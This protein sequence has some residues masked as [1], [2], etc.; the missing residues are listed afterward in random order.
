M[1]VH[2][3]IVRTSAY[4]TS[5]AM[6]SSDMKYRYLLSRTWNGQRPHLCWLMLN[7][8]TATEEV[9]DPTVERCERRTRS[10]DTYGGMIVL[11]LYAYR[12]TDPRELWNVSDPVGPYNDSTIE[13]NLRGNS[14]VVCAWGANAKSERSAKVRDVLRVLVNRNKLTCYHLGLS[15]NG[16]PRHPLYIPYSTKPELWIP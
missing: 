14:F 7:P 16:T 12:A 11:N 13:I 4:G 10:D 8:S 1:M 9:N 6:Y 5:V 2:D 15:R 3:T